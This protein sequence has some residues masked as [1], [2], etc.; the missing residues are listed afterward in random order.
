MKFRKKPIVVE[1]MKF[2][3]NGP[4]Q[5]KVSNWM[6][7]NGGELGLYDGFVEHNVKTSTSATWRWRSADVETLEGTMPVNIGD[8]IIKG[9]NG[10]F[11]PVKDDIFRKTYEPVEEVEKLKG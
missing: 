9:I 10:E 3:D 8:W 1:A 2:P 7:D 5:A 6:E 4:D 11:Y